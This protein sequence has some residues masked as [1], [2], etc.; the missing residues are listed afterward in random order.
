MLFSC[1]VVPAANEMDG[2]YHITIMVTTEQE[3]AIIQLYKDRHWLYIKTGM[4]KGMQH[5]VCLG[6]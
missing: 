6:F 3:D 2:F 5:I 4:L 1:R